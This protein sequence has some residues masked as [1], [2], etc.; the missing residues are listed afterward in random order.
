MDRRMILVMTMA[1]MSGVGVIG[2]EGEEKEVRP[3]W[4]ARKVA[5]DPLFFVKP[6]G[7]A[8][9]AL[10]LR[11]P[12]KAPVVR[13]ATLERTYEAG[14]DYTWKEGTREIVLVEG[15]R[16]PF[17]TEGE[18]HPPANAPHSY[19]EQR[20]GKA[21]MLFGE[22][23]WFHDLQ[24][25]AAYEAADDWA[26]PKVAA[27]PDEQLGGLRAQLR[28]GETIR[29]VTL[30]DSIST[31]ANASGSAAAPPM[32]GGYPDLVAAGLEEQFGVKVAA[33][34]LSVSG[35]DSAWGREQVGAVVA[36]R[37]DLVLLAFGMNDAS[38]RRTPE[39]FASITGEIRDRI[40]K[41]RPG[42]S[43]IVISP[44][45]AN[46]EWSHSAPELYPAYAAA[47][48]KL[49]GAGTAAADVTAVWTAVAARKTYLSLTGNGL[50]HPND[51]G[52]R[53]YA[54]VVLAVI[55]APGR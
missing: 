37:P 25:V 28:R 24:S 7:G 51:F 11:V 30:G 9:T 29:M 18:L 2:A 8:A 47:L 12:L 3:V 13:S 38:G 6:A 34:N 27:A 46:P 42:C 45:T 17:K 43:V 10:L 4:E 40:R 16:I 23:R 55:G 14:R 32:Q 26:G 39:E 20:G 36:E 33:K 50:N 15:T 41:E 44:M 53:L 21:W 48:G 1:A 54:D 49:A 22:G 5:G 19:R 35:M 52:H 31:G